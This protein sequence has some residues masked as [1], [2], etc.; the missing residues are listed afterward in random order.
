[1]FYPTPIILSVGYLTKYHLH[2]HALWQGDLAKAGQYYKDCLTVFEAD[3]EED[4][5][6]CV[7][8]QSLGRWSIFRGCLAEAVDYLHK[9]LAIRYRRQDRDGAAYCAIY[10]AEA[11]IQ[12]NQLAEAQYLLVEAIQTCKALQ[13]QLGEAMGYLAFA[14]LEAK[15]GLFNEAIRLC[16]QSLDLLTLVPMPVI[17]LQAVGLM[18]V[19]SIRTGQLQTL[20]P[21]LNR[22]RAVWGR[23]SLPL[24][25]RLRFFALCFAT[26]H[27]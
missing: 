6:A 25:Q 9:G 8:Y 17:E 14:R 1:M 10:L 2:T 26:I 4:N 7:A 3:G 11:Y 12:D 5:L 23:Q 13:H 20:L 19:L 21:L 18:G 24:R 27:F 16:R 22:L 15:R